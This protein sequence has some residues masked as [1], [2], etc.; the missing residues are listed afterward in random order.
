[1]HYYAGQTLR[2]VVKRCEWHC[3]NAKLLL[4]EATKDTY[5]NFKDYE[6]VANMKNVILDEGS[7]NKVQLYIT[8]YHS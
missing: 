1:M 5:S 3:R 6:C 4:D 7:G 8:Q 2:S